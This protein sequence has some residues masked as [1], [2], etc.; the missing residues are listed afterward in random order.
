MCKHKKMR[1]IQ[2]LVE[3]GCIG[4]RQLQFD[5]PISTSPH[6]LL[7]FVGVVLPFI[8]VCSFFLSSLHLLYFE[9]LK[10]LPIFLFLIFLLRSAMETT[11][12]P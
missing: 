7:M 1:A 2:L 3:D 8:H 4:V 12:V 11:M 9:L 6:I 5:A 10:L